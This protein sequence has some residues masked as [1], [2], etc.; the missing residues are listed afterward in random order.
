M[1]GKWQY[2]LISLCLYHT[3]ANCINFWMWIPLW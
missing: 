3:L 2:K 1:K